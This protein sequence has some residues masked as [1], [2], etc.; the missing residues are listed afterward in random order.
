MREGHWSEQ[1]ACKGIDTEAFFAENANGR[2]YWKFEEIC[3]SCPVAMLCRISS[4]G[5]SDGFWAG[6]T[7]K[8][9]L[10]FRVYWGVSDALG[11]L[12]TEGQRVAADA[13]RNEIT[14]G[15]AARHWLGPVV[16]NAWIDWYAPTLNERDYEEFYGARQSA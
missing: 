8:Q 15:I 10:R 14:P 7:P 2:A 13:W 1:A 9:R 4:L 6:L 5:E 16:G 12:A 3:Q 11:T